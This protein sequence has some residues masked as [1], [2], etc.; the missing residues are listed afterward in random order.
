MINDT[1]ARY[2]ALS[3]FFHWLMALLIIQQF[4]K[5]GDRINDGEHW[6]GDTFGSFH[7]SIGATILLLVILR[8]LWALRQQS[9][10]P[11][12]SGATA[13]AVRGGHILLYLCMFLMPV[14]GVLYM[15]GNGYGL[16]VFGSQLIA[17]SGVETD[18][19][20][21]L[22]SLHS[23]IA[24]VFLVLLL[25][26]VGIALVHHFIKRDGVLRRML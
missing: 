20:L 17:K 8:A 25:G 4:F 22:G 23:P 5:L 2:G 9:S 15:L 7:L 11:Q 1:A 6:L 21:S 18:W 3:K 24:R 13:W 10:R 26:H 14:T 16:K 12:H 19:M